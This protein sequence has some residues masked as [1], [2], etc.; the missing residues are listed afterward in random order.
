MKVWQVDTQNLIDEVTNDE[1]KIHLLRIYT[2]D[3]F[4]SNNDL[5]L[6]NQKERV[7]YF[8]NKEIFYQAVTVETISLQ[9]KIR[10][11]IDALYEYKIKTG[12]K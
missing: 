5:C 2:P 6:D 3:Y 1:F 11:L 10:H 7:A 9:K 12:K 8:K 4:D